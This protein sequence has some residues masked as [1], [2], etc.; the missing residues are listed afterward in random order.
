MVQKYVKQGV[1]TKEKTLAEKTKEREPRIQA[2]IAARNAVL[3]LSVY[4]RMAPSAL[5][6]PA[7]SSGSS[8]RSN[9]KDSSTCAPRT[10]AR[11]LRGLLPGSL[12]SGGSG[13]LLRLQQRTR[14]SLIG[15][16]GL[17]SRR[18][19]GARGPPVALRLGPGFTLTIQTAGAG[20]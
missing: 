11:L 2:S 7:F 12:L 18:L 3:S 4:R 13:F 9:A 14:P 19:R 16:C 5:R 1:E 17:M 8:P 6:Q 20:R 15:F 10:S